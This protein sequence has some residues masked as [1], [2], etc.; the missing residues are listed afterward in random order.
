MQDLKL[1]K[2]NSYFKMK[3]FKG[4]RFWIDVHIRP[5][6]P[7]FSCWISLG[8]FACEICLYI[9][10]HI[11]L[12]SKNA[13]SEMYLLFSPSCA[14][15]EIDSFPWPSGCGFI[16]SSPV[17]S[18]V[19]MHHL[20]TMEVMVFISMFWSLMLC[21]VFLTSAFFDVYIFCVNATKDK[22]HAVLLYYIYFHA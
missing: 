17:Y 13:Q 5:S 1:C 16:R 20:I 8:E 15:L 2:E 3:M 7:E 14:D 9:R 6:R 10:L 12:E 19:K 21:K 11:C 18:I 22:N 4:L